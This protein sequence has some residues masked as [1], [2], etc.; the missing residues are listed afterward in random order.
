MTNG[1]DLPGNKLPGQSWYGRLFR[2]QILPLGS[3]KDNSF[4]FF[5][6]CYCMYLS[7]FVLL[8]D[9]V[10]LLACMGPGLSPGRYG[11]NS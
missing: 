7:V 11:A 5:G 6:L 2:G 9:C 10:L 4:V 1:D 3:K 8:F